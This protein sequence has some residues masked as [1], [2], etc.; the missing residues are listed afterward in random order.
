VENAQI[1]LD[2]VKLVKLQDIIISPYI[3]M[4]T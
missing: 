2:E 3:L 4:Q 1:V